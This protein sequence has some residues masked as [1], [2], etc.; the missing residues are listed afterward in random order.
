MCVHVV[1]KHECS[2]MYICVYIYYLFCLEPRLESSSGFYPR[3]RLSL[4]PK[5]GPHKIVAMPVFA[6]VLWISDQKYIICLKIENQNEWIVWPGKDTVNDKQSPEHGAQA[7]RC[8]RWGWCWRVSS[9]LKLLH[10]ISFQPYRV[11]IV[12]HLRTTQLQSPTMHLSEAL[13]S[14]DPESGLP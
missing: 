12:S 1:C 10:L 4:R 2:Y 8:S 9:G 7:H 6:H 14:L 5:C 13:E 3:A 11:G